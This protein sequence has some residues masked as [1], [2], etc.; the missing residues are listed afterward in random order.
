[1]RIFLLLILFAYPYILIGKQSPPASSNHEKVTLQQFDFA[2]QKLREQIAIVD[3][4]I[5]FANKYEKKAEIIQLYI[6]K[7]DM[8]YRNNTYAAAYPI[9]DSAIS[10]INRNKNA[11]YYRQFLPKLYLQQGKISYY[12]GKYA[13]GVAY[14]YDLLQLDFKLSPVIKVQAY[15]QLSNLYIRMEKNNLALRYLNEAQHFMRTIQIG[16]SVTDSV[17]RQ[18]QSDLLIAYSSVFL[19]KQDAET[20]LGY[21]QQAQKT[22]TA[23]NISRLYQN[24]SILHLMTNDIKG[25]E[26]YCQKALEEART[27]YDRSVILNNYSIMCYEQKDLDKALQLCKQN[28]EEIKRI[29]ATHVKSNLYSILSNIYS[30]KK[31]YKQ[32][33]FYRQREQELIDSIFNKESE[34]RIM[35]LN[36]EFE[37]AKIKQDKTLLEYKLKIMELSNFRKNTFIVL[38]IIFAI[39][40]IIGI[41]LLIRRGR[42]QKQKFEE[43][44]IH[45]DEEKNQFI[46]S[47]KIEYETNISHKSRKLTANALFMAH[48]SE[49]ATKIQSQINVLVSL[50]KD[51]DLLSIIKDIQHELTELTSEKKDWEDFCIQFEEIHPS[52]FSRL[53]KAH[54]KLTLGESRMCAFILM[55][56]N[57]KEIALLTNRSTRTVETIKFRIRKKLDIPKEI[58]TLTYLRSFISENETPEQTQT[59]NTEDC[60]E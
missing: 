44:L 59:D 13:T 15:T 58:N 47:S 51:K 18:I 41:Y 10:Y 45:L 57:T 6:K 26:K 52:F 50:I 35:Q 53:S 16:G 46:H 29:D 25:A 32:A 49:V 22:C 60:A 36:N 14:L 28:L 30:E 56:I 11:K 38:L 34:E 27:P 42:K 39:A 3:S 24:F 2:A 7:A 19:Q 33:L 5:A 23:N 48:T 1:M 9:Y 43:D 21:I 40:I 4:Q 12:L 37:T 54:P 55:N 17:Y 31:D 8:E 20:A